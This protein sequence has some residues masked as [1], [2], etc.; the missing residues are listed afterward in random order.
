MIITAIFLVIVSIMILASVNGL[1]RTV[2]A[3]QKKVEAIYRSTLSVLAITEAARYNST[4]VLANVTVVYGSMIPK[5]SLCDMMVT[6]TDLTLNKT[7]T[8]H[9]NYGTAPGWQVLRVIS[10]NS[11]YSI[12]NHDYL[13]PGEKAELAIY[14]PTESLMED[15]VVV[16]FASPNG[17]SATRVAG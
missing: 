11:I 8:F 12:N 16:V 5:L 3:I 9:L 2:D 17:A 4:V 15:P 7:V 13:L 1:M 6:Y 14:L 10:G